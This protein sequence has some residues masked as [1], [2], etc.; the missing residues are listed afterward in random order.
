MKERSVGTVLIYNWKEYTRMKERDDERKKERTN[1]DL[2][3]VSKHKCALSNGQSPWKNIKGWNN[4]WSVHN[5]T[6]I[7]NFKTIK[8]KFLFL[9]VEF[10]ALW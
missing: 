10:K 7:D 3:N 2:R 6:K 5:A 1:E 9:F 4:N 8:N